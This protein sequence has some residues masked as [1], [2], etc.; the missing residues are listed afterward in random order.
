MSE[1]R[2]ETVRLFS[3]FRKLT[4]GEEV[5]IDEV[6]EATNDIYTMSGINNISQ[7]GAQMEGFK[8]AVLA[9]LETLSAGIASFTESTNAKMDA[10]N[11]STN[12]KIDALNESTNTKMDALNESTNTKIDALTESANAKLDAQNS[13]YNILLW[14][15]GLFGGSI[16]LILAYATFFA[17]Q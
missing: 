17:E 4:E 6:H 10:L 11:E 8:E 2:P 14:M 9:R 15:I 3:F 5:S 7:F 1:Q 12:T 16:S 13:K